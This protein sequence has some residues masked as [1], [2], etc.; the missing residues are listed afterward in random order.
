[1]TL[2]LAFRAALAAVTVL[3]L[4][5]NVQAQALSGYEE[6]RR[7][8]NKNLFTIVTSGLQTAYAKFGADIAETLNGLPGA[9]TRVIA[10]LSEG[11]GQNVLDM[12]LLRGVDGG[13]ISPE[14]VKW[15]QRKD[16]AR[17]GNLGQ[18]INYII[19]LFDFKLHMIA[20]R[21]ITSLEQLRGKKVSCLKAIS[22]A[23]ILCENIFL[24]LGIDAEIVNDSVPVA[25]QKL[26]SGEIAAAARGG[27]TPLPGFET[28]KPEDNLHFIPIDAAHLPNSP[29]DKIKNDYLPA[30]LRASEYPTM[31]T[32]GQDVP[33]LATP[34][35][36][37]VYGWPAGSERYRN[38]ENFVRVFFDNIDK[39]AGPPRHPGW[40][41]INI[42]ADVAGMIRFPAAQ[43]WLDEKRKSQSYA[44]T[45]VSP[46]ENLK[47]AFAD[48]MTKYVRGKGGAAIT[49]SEK[50]EM[51]RQFQEWSAQT[52]SSR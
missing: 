25:M 14:E 45:A 22:T 17:Y 6:M 26:K 31:I 29:F 52:L 41:D 50:D 24:A 28:I 21:D 36:L 19:K 48:F 18:R 11:G 8:A 30:R 13:V 10:M 27:P 12:Y 15:L 39:F 44:T 1:M 16:P 40:K 47:R 42:A 51:W 7:D 49:E 5:N 3:I 2:R 32:D 46:D 9:D 20:K 35:V 4:T 33:S 34:A 37:G 23:A 43:K 38:V